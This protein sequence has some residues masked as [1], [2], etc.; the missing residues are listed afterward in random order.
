MK[1]AGYE[2][3]PKADRTFSALAT[4]SATLPDVCERF[5]LITLEQ[6]NDL[7]KINQVLWRGFDHKGEAPEE[8]I[9]LRR[10]MQSSPNFRFDLTVVAVSPSGDYAAYCGMWYDRNNAFGYVEPV[11]TDPDYRR[12]GLGS[13]VVLESTRRCRNLG[14]EVVYVWNDKPFYRSMEFDPLFQHHCWTKAL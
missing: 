14:A 12:R 1:E 6:E 9:E 7:R 3:L 5:K 10:R 8:D 2:Y 4:S 13:A 11:A